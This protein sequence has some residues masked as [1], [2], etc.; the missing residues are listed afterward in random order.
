M[1]IDSGKDSAR[2]SGMA[3]EGAKPATQVTATTGPQEGPPSQTTSSAHPPAPTPETAQQMR[4]K[5]GVEPHR[6]S[7]IRLILD[8]LF[9]MAGM[10]TYVADLATDV[11]VAVQYILLDEYEWS[12]LTIAFIIIPSI[13]IQYFS[14]RWFVLDSKEV[15]KAEHVPFLK[16]VMDWI[17][18]LLFHVLQLGVLKRYW[19][20]VKY[21]WRSREKRDYYDL[22]VYEYRDLTMLRLLESFMEAAPQLV[23]QIYIMTQQK[24]VY[25]LTAT[26]AIISLASLAWGIEAYH[27]ALREACS[28]KNNLGYIGLTVRMAW[29][30]FTITAR[31]ISLALF[32]AYSLWSFVALV[33]VHY[34]AMTLWLIYQDTD[35]CTTRLEEVLF[36]CVIG[37][38]HIF[39]FFN[40]K[41][42]RTRYRAAFFYT[43]ILVENTVMFA[44]WY[45][46]EGR[47]TDYGKAALAF[48]WGGFFLGI[49]IML[50]YYR[51]LHPNGSI[52]LFGRAPSTPAKSRPAGRTPEGNAH[53][54]ENTGQDTVDSPLSWDDVV[55]P[56]STRGCH[57]NLFTR[58]GRRYCYWR[59]QDGPCPCEAP[60]SNQ[61]TTTEQPV[62]NA[63]DHSTVVVEDGAK[64][65]NCHCNGEEQKAF[66]HDGKERLETY[67]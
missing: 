5:T 12:G 36:D 67:L 14:F 27:K 56:S 44:L 29:R 13:T 52:R 38:I 16:K 28:N 35:F 63:V 37:I 32:A 45:H 39:C 22:S 53:S 33:G 23:L 48:V 40:M 43:V 19:R 15:R 42:G 62:P 9:L 59:V 34:V 64:D 54:Y 7:R 24:D 1:R 60:P 2:G 57:G 41:E 30:T 10:A 66:S 31:V 55:I 49:F 50:L 21:G 61:S 11:S 3:D 26:S 20:T 8:A 18:W 58:R 17:L 25:W 4:R 6:V 51:C 46:Y 65:V 47:D